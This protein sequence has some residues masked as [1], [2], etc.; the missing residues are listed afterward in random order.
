[1]QQRNKLK[2]QNPNKYSNREALH[3][4]LRGNHRFV[5]RA[6]CKSTVFTYLFILFP[7]TPYLGKFCMWSRR[8]FFLPEQVPKWHLRE[9]GALVESLFPFWNL[10]CVWVR[11][12]GHGTLR[13]FS[14]ILIYLSKW[15][16]GMVGKQK[17]QEHGKISE[18]VYFYHFFAVWRLERCFFFLTV[19][20]CFTCHIWLNFVAKWL[21]CIY[22]SNG[23]WLGGNKTI[24]FARKWVCDDYTSIDPKL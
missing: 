20:G 16:L 9:Q 19:Q 12:T 3:I 5:F 6:T 1:M 8:W 11:K 4:Q 24:F 15:F 22:F 23:D 7:F 10:N 21:L 2:T 17:T 13:I 18:N 14:M